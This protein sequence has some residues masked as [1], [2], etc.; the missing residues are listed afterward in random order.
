MHYAIGDVHGCYDEMMALLS[1]IETM[2]EDAQFIFVGDFVD[3]GPQIDMVLEWCVNHITS[4][5][6]YQAV[7]GNHEQMALDQLLEWADSMNISASEKIHAYMN[8]FSSL[9][10]DKLLKI[11]SKWGRMVD[12]RIVHSFYEYGDISQ[13]EQHQ[14]NLWKRMY[15]GNHISDEIIVHGHTPTIDFEYIYWSIHD[16]KPGMISYRQ[17]DI[18]IDGGCVFA[19]EFPMYPAMLCAIRLEDLEEVYAYT[20]EERFMQKARD[21]VEESYQRERLERHTREYLNEQ[22]KCRRMLLKKLGYPGDKV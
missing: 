13:E 12:F 14:A 9:P 22:G 15:C 11:Q 20:V 6:K 8:F 1:K 19:K 2:D 21:G 5:G 4:N 16:T 7:R 17:N 10:Y 3:R 18:N